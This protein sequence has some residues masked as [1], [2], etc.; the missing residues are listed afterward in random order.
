VHPEPLGVPARNV[1]LPT[2]GFFVTA[3]NEAGESEF[4]NNISRR[5]PVAK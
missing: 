5:S 2:I 4:A 1:D 3:M